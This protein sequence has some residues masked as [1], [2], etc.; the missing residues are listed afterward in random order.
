M[1]MSHMPQDR[2]VRKT[3]ANHLIPEP[4]QMSEDK[5]TWLGGGLQSC[6]MNL[7][8]SLNPKPC[9]LYFTT[10]PLCFFL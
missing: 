8:L 9:A 5:V 2:P 1:D 10:L 3:W 4:S 6:D 7:T